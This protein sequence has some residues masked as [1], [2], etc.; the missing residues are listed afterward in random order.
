[1]PAAGSTVTITARYYDWYQTDS[2][3]DPISGQGFS[4]TVSFT[5]VSETSNELSLGDDLAANSYTTDSQLNPD[6]A[7]L[8][9]GDAVV[10][11]QSGGQGGK[12]DTFYHGIYGQK[13]SSTG[14]ASG[15]E[16]VISNSASDTDEINPSIASLG[17]GRYVVA[18]GRW[19]TD[20]YD[21]CYRL[22]EA[23]GTVVRS[24]ADGG[25]G[26][27]WPLRPA[28]LRMPGSESASR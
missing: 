12:A 6:V 15:S 19:L 23:N 1:M 20:N 16:F 7:T 27:A 5:V 14:T 21:I 2:S 4:E 11:W 17:S 25:L 28:S 9:T 26:G 8:S 13:F 10:V 22:V 3:G 24:S 18:Y